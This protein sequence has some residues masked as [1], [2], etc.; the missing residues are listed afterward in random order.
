MLWGKGYKCF[1]IFENSWRKAGFIIPNKT[2]VL[3][4]IISMSPHASFPFPPCLFSNFFFVLLIFLFIFCLCFAFCFTFHFFFTFCVTF[5]GRIYR[6]SFLTNSLSLAEI[7]TVYRPSIFS[8]RRLSIFSW[9]DCKSV[10]VTLFLQE[11]VISRIIIWQGLIR[12]LVASSLTRIHH[13]K[14]HCK[15]TIRTLAWI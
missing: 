13:L 7:L 5:E 2:W 4:P 6:T 14:N 1:D 10:I 15:S 8:W 3:L 9:R 11:K 12:V